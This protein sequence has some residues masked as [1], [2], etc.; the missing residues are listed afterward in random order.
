MKLNIKGLV[1]A[2]FSP[3]NQNG[4]LNLEVIPKL[5]EELINDGIKGF[6]LLGS[7]GEGLSLTTQQRMAVTEAYISSV[8]KRVQ[9]IVNV[10]HTSYEVSHELTKHAIENG[11]NA[12]SATLPT[13]YGISNLEQLIAAVRKIADCQNQVPFI[14]YH[15]PGKTGLN[16][17]MH[18][19]LEQI[20]D[21][22]PQLGGI[23]YTAPD[24][25]DFIICKHR[26]GHKYE[27]FFG[28]DELFLPALAIGA[29]S[30][31]GSTY[32]FMG[33]FYEDLMVKYAAKKKK[34][35]QEAYYQIVQIIDTFLKYDGLAAQKG[36]MKMIGHDFG[37][38]RSPVVS[39]TNEEYNN[40]R[41]NLKKINYFE[42]M[43]TQKF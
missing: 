22:I 19:F 30:F 40:L 23:K 37:G 9:V 6:Y 32:N 27:M 21:T 4:S 10:S 35:F 16:F 25:D 31:I 11:A 5:V 18:S 24:I 29:D 15:I 20:G 3:F 41:E 14:Y 1:A 43:Q 13:Y 8:N 7:T 26:Y 2:T 33:R 12:I 36:I 38:T 42:N 17:K 34:E 39:L 28:V